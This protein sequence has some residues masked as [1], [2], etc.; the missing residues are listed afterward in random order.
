MSPCKVCG[1]SGVYAEPNVYGEPD[2]AVEP[3]GRCMGTGEEED[4]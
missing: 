1:G 4:E 2:D 3:C